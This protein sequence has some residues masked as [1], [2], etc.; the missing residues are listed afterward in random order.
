[1]VLSVTSWQKILASRHKWL[2]LGLGLLTVVYMGSAL[3]RSTDMTDSPVNEIA[4]SLVNGEGYTR[5]FRPYF[6]FCQEGDETAS[7]EPIRILIL[8]A[9][10][11]VFG[12][13]V[14]TSALVNTLYGVGTG[15]LIYLIG[16][17]LFVDW[18]VALFAV[19]VWAVY[20]PAIRLVTQDHVEL[21]SAFTLALMLWTFIRALDKPQ[22]QRFAIAGMCFGIAVLTR[23]TLLYAVLLLPPGLY[24]FFG[25]N[26]R[27][28]I[29]RSAI[30]V[31][32]FVLVMTPWVVR[33]YAIFGRFI[34]GTTLS[35]YVFFRTA[36]ILPE[37]NFLRYTTQTETAEAIQKRFS[38][39]T[40]VRGDEDEGETDR[41]LMAEALEIIKDHPVRYLTLVTHRFMFFQWFDYGVWKVHGD[42]R[43]GYQ[44]FV[45][46]SNL[47]ML[48]LA[49][50]GIVRLPKENWR[51]AWPII[52]VGVLINL[53]YPLVNTQFRYMV[54]LMPYVFLFAGDRLLVVAARYFPNCF[55]QVGRE[56]QTNYES[57]C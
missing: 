35:G 15:I 14:I 24:L 29:A 39:R 46:M 37:D 11:Q 5:C 13:S 26:W 7:R 10:G 41:L 6:V 27:L 8:A 45:L 49:I 3:F 40:D 48:P 43:Q 31:G 34:P 56:Q 36:F 28:A 21:S 50:W 44:M 38:Q 52:G 32:M 55:P 30:F 17:R 20:P 51:Y 1:M 57:A 54:P 47:I 12:L 23:S 2:V 4:I 9:F 18:R 25:R 16:L 33:N 19:F 22:W 53:V 42:Q